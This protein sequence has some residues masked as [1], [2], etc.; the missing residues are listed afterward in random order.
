MSIEDE[1]KRDYEQFLQQLRVV[2]DEM[3]KERG[4][5]LR[6]LS[7]HLRTVIECA[8]FSGASFISAAFLF[9][10]SLATNDSA[11]RIGSIAAGAAGFTCVT[12]GMHRAWPVLWNIAMVELRLFRSWLSLKRALQ[13]FENHPSFKGTLKDKL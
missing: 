9:A 4:K 1:F 3:R 11:W 13:R 12:V 7:P 5:L 6:Q 10:G 8:I 2:V